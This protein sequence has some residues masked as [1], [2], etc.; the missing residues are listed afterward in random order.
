MKIH[1]ASSLQFSLQKDYPAVVTVLE[2]TASGVFLHRTTCHNFC[3]YFYGKYISRQHP[4][5][6][7]VFKQAKN[8]LE[9]SF[10]C[11]KLNI[12]T[13]LKTGLDIKIFCNLYL[14]PVTG[15]SKASEPHM[16]PTIEFLASS[17]V[18]LY[19]ETRAMLSEDVKLLQP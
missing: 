1:W 3:I 16:K 13:A 2:G 11:R 8:Y 6:I 19:P 14:F 4:F 12:L 10:T 7:Q 5:L 17:W 15:T 9:A 18:F